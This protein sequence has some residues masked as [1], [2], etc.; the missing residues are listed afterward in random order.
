MRVRFGVQCFLGLT[1]TATN[2]T[3]TNISQHLNLSDSETDTIRGTLLPPNLN[4]SVSKDNNK[5]SVSGDNSLD[6]E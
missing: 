1:A 4:L 6:L 5:E 2:E 3:I